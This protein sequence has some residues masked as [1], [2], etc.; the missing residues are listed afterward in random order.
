[1]KN[2]IL[3]EDAEDRLIDA[4]E[5]NDSEDLQAM[6]EEGYPIATH[7]FSYGATALRYALGEANIQLHTIQTLL[8]LGSSI[9]E[10]FKGQEPIFTAV[11]N[12]NID[13]SIITLLIRSGADPR[14]EGVVGLA[15]RK[16][17]VHGNDQ[18]FF[19]LGGQALVDRMREHRE[20]EARQA[21]GQEAEDTYFNSAAA[22]ANR[23]TLGKIANGG[24]IVLCIDASMDPA[25]VSM[26]TQAFVDL[27]KSLTIA[28]DEFGASYQELIKFETDSH[29]SGEIKMEAM[30][31]SAQ[32]A[33]RLEPSIRYFFRIGGVELPKF[34]LS[35]EVKGT[36]DLTLSIIKTSADTALMPGQ[37]LQSG[38]YYAGLKIYE[39]LGTA[40][41]VQPVFDLLSFAKNCGGYIAAGSVIG[42]GMGSP[43]YG[44]ISGAAMC[45]DKH[46]QLGLANHESPEQVDFRLA[47]DATAAIFASSNGIIGMISA[48]VATDIT[49]KVASATHELGLNG[50][51]SYFASED[52]LEA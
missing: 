36:L 20:Y 12:I 16:Q 9:G 41:V 4:I 43:L 32:N 18:I 34:D 52:T 19:A 25:Y 8:A 24:K 1:M 3:D 17:Y 44:A 11:N 7:K 14:A 31:L 42:L 50:L 26:Q 28:A 40:P 47:A 5:A 49:A 15:M 29:S 21:A 33:L 39:M 51:M 37:V 27:A 6:Q 30:A 2:K 23:V 35:S 38:S 10:T 22:T 46:Q 48:V 45:L 13:P